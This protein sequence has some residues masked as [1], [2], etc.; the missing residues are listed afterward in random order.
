MGFAERAFGD[1][2]ERRLDGTPTEIIDTIMRWTLHADSPDEEEQI[3]KVPKLSARVLW[4]CG[5]AGLGKS[6][7]S[8]SIAMRLQELERL[9]SLYCCEA[10]RNRD[11]AVTR[12]QSQATKL[13]LFSSFPLA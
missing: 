9:G 6:R 4:L 2:Q 7:I 10:Q 11:S 13:Q 3:G 1:V 12:S 5:V 8:R